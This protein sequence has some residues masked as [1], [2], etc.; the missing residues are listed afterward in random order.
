MEEG[1]FL[2]RV[3]LYADHGQDRN[4]EQ[5]IEI[6]I[7]VYREESWSLG[8]TAC[9]CRTLCGV[10][11]GLG[12]APHSSFFFRFCFLFYGFLVEWQGEMKSRVGKGR[13]QSLC[14]KSG[15]AGVQ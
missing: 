1:P 6:S 10:G 15:P 5:L 2:P 7:S 14:E 8:Y 11:G 4:C 9:T 3:L 13:P 12:L